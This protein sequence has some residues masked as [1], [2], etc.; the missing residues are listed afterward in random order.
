MM[1]SK[2]IRTKYIGETAIRREMHR[3]GEGCIIN[4]ISLFWNARMR[5]IEM[6]SFYGWKITKN[7]KLVHQNRSRRR[8]AHCK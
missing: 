6:N 1:V 3:L 2:K 5:T 8:K 7:V 4:Q